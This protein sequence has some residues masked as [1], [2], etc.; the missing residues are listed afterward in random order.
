MLPHAA[1]A[2]DANTVMVMVVVVVLHYCCSY[3][4]YFVI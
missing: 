1:T 3:I 2:V 4:H